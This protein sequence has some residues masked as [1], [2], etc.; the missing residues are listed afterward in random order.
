MERLEEQMQKQKEG[1]KG[2]KKK[3]KESMEVKI[4]TK[5]REWKSNKNVITVTIK[6]RIHM[7]YLHYFRLFW[8]F[9]L[10]YIFIAVLQNAYIWNA[11]YIEKDNNV[12]K[13]NLKI[14]YRTLTICL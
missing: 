3:A 10:F 9:R 2:S 7:Q 12:R 11:K 14:A 8:I 5:W 6:Y 4:N 1:G 13:A